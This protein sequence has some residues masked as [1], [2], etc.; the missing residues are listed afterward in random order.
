MTKER[1]FSRP[2]IVAFALVLVLGSAGWISYQ[3]KKQL[4]NEHTTLALLWFQ[5]SAECRALYYQAFNNARHELDEYL[6]T[7]KPA[8]KPAV[9]VDI[10]DTI[11]D[12]SPHS[13]MLLK[14][15]QIFPYR[16]DEW[17]EGAKEEPLPGGLEFLKYA[18]SR[19]VDVYYISNRLA[20][21]LP[22]TVK[23][24]QAF[25]FPQAEESHILL[26]GKESS[27][28]LR[29]QSVAADH[30]VILLMGDNL[31]DLSNVFENKSIAGRAEEVD[32][33]KELFGP[34]YIVLPNPVYG[35]WESAAYGNGSKLSEQEKDVKRKEVLK[36]F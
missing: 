20:A 29:R 4:R 35:A 27:K 23:N 28:E 7:H 3:Q 1:F 24:L 9:I 13:V 30:E 15:N 21:Q 22:A 36:S 25:G 16:Y 31:N 32:K 14:E 8:K 17:I 5:T 19:G 33:V 6:L 18:S 12:D 34:K 26:M 2:T 11:L 10:D